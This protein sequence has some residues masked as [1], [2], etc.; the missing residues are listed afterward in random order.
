MYALL[1][2]MMMMMTNK[3]MMTTTPIAH[4]KNVYLMNVTL[5]AE[6]VPWLHPVLL[7]ARIS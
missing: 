1:L 6:T 3:M 2:T 4:K 7:I 5:D